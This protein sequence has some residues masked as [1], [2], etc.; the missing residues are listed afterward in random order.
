MQK[1]RLLP[2][3]PNVYNYVLLSSLAT[4]IF[5]LC[6]FWVLFA[7]SFIAFIFILFFYVSIL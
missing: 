1:R 3:A 2:I 6:E 5:F 4:V 7:L